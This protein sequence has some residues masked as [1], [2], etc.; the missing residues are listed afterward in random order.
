VTQVPIH[1]NLINGFLKDNFNFFK[2]EE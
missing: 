1:M 2:D